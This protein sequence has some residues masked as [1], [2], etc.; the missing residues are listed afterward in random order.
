MP[1]IFLIGVISLTCAMWRITRETCP[2]LVHRYCRYCSRRRYN[3]RFAIPRYIALSS[4]SALL[5]GNSYSKLSSERT[6]PLRLISLSEAHYRRPYRQ[7]FEPP[8]ELVISGYAPFND[9]LESYRYAVDDDI[10]I[11]ANISP[12]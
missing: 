2:R 10:A 1:L 11:A 7:R 8:E 6:P 12:C 5:L 4:I 9:G 3:T